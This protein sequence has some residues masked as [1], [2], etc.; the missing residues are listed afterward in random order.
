MYGSGAAP[1]SGG[2]ADAVFRAQREAYS[3]MAKGLRDERF[4]DQ[5][6]KPLRK[7]EIRGA[8]VVAG[9]GA[10]PGGVFPQPSEKSYCMGLCPRVPGTLDSVLQAK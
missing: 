10:A 9:G 5:R 4:E 7:V 6:G 3:S 2:V 1:G 8:R